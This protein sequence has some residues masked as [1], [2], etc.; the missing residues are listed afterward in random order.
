MKLKIFFQPADKLALPNY[1]PSFIHE[2]TIL[3]LVTNPIES[4]PQCPFNK[5]L[6]GGHDGLSPEQVRRDAIVCCFLRR[7][8]RTM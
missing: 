7:K 4:L 8:E 3:L 6:D 5:E 2:S 1:F